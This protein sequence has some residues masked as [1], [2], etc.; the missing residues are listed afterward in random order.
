MILKRTGHKMVLF[1]FLLILPE[2]TVVKLS[3]WQ[4]NICSLTHYNKKWNKE[5]N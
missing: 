2:Q 4:N 1:L 5:L 3:C